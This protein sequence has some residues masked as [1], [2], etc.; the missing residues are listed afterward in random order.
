VSYVKQKN[1]FLPKRNRSCAIFELTTCRAWT[2]ERGTG[3]FE[4]WHFLSNF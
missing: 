2:S 4:I 3:D 1:H